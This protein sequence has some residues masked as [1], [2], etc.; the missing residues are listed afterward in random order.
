MIK[1]THF[2]DK[3]TFQITVIF[4]IMIQEKKKIVLVNWEI[5]D[6]AEKLKINAGRLC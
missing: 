6:M 1:H 3:N 4:F 2:Y 5:E